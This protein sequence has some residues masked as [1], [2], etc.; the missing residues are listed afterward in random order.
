MPGLVTT[1]FGV[2]RSYIHLQA[3]YDQVK[4][5]PSRGALTTNFLKGD[6]QPLQYLK[7]IKGEVHPPSFWSACLTDAAS[8]PCPQ[9]CIF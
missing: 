7:D 2:S 4:N 8:L 3:A 6:S 5:A 9:R 1:R